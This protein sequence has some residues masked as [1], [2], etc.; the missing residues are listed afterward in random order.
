MSRISFTHRHVYYR[1][2]HV[3]FIP[4][5]NVYNGARVLYQRC[6]SNHV[7]SG[8]TIDHSYIVHHV[9]C[10]HITHQASC[11]KS[12]AT[13]YMPYT[14]KLHT[15]YIICHSA[16]I[17]CLTSCVKHNWCSI[18]WHTLHIIHRMPHTQKHQSLL[19]CNVSHITQYRWCVMGFMLCVGYYI[20][21]LNTTFHGNQ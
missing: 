12:C 15:S 9:L 1:L 4:P 5:C 19:I 3:S 14:T 7:H 18:I 10:M 16:S 20:S 17:D 8:T 11:H 13:S 6:T 21:N 2:D